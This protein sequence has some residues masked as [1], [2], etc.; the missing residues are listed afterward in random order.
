VQ[1]PRPLF[2][3]GA[4]LIGTASIAGSFLLDMLGRLILIRAAAFGEGVTVA[5]GK[6][7]SLLSSRLGAC[8]VITLAFMLL[9]LIV[10]ATVG[11][12]TSMLSA[13]AFFDPDL[14]LLALAPRIAAGLAAAAIFSWLEIGHMGAFSA[15]AL[16]A[17]GL[18]EPEV[19][20]QP[21]PPIPIADPVIE[22][23]PADDE[24]APSE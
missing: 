15:L 2:V 10:A 6:A 19:P 23:L 5:F 8:F 17:E 9:D 20:P 7:V 11:T 21:P 16:D 4:A 22:A 14:E 3:A 13:Q 12:L 18:I 24:I 1:H